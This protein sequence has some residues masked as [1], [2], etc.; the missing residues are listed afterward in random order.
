[1]YWSHADRA[2]YRRWLQRLGFGILTEHYIPEGAEGGHAVFIAR[3]DSTGPVAAA[4][5]EAAGSRA[6]LA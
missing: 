3:K 1:M 4:A 6:G 5:A 2:T